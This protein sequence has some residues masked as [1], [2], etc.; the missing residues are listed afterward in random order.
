MSF[1]SLEIQRRIL[2]TEVYYEF[3]YQSNFFSW[4]NF[5]KLFLQC[6]CYWHKLLQKMF[7]ILCEYW[8]KLFFTKVYV[9]FTIVILWVFFSRHVLAFFETNDLKE[10]LILIFISKILIPKLPKFQNEALMYIIHINFLKY[11]YLLMHIIFLY[12]GNI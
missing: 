10:I 11:F 2:E 5:E 12:K 1:F 9:F 7:F 6:V 8:K 4:S 3:F